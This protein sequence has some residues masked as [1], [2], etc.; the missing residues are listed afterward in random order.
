V[1]REVDLGPLDDLPES[2]ITPV[3]AGRRVLALVRKGD[4]VYAVR[5]S[6]PHMSTSFVG[7]CV[8]DQAAGG[9]GAPAFQHENPIITCPWHRF[10]FALRTGQCLTH[11]GLRIKVYPVTV[12]DG[13]IRVDLDSERH[14]SASSARLPPP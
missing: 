7:G 10:E 1:A 6:C 2:V 3:K 8:G 12:A 11:S 14:L 4:E 9:V 5:D 13:R